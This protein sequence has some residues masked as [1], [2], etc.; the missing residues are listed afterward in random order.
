MAFV[1]V[2]GCTTLSEPTRVQR[3]SLVV[4]GGAR[5]VGLG[6]QATTSIELQAQPPRAC[7]R[8][9]RA[10]REMTGRA[11]TVALALAG[12][13]P[14]AAE[15]RWLRIGC[16]LAMS[17]FT[18]SA[19]GY[20]TA[21][22][23]PAFTGTAKVRWDGREVGYRLHSSIPAALRLEDVSAAAEA[24]A[25]RWAEAS[26]NHIRFKLERTTDEAAAPDDGVNT[27]QFVETGWEERGFDPA[28]AAITDV[29]YV[30]NSVGNWVIAEADL[31]LNAENH[32]FG[33]SS[34]VESNSRDLNSVL[35]HEVGHMLGLW[36]PCELGG[37]NGAPDCS[38][39]PDFETVTMYPVYAQH[40]VSLADDDIAGVNFLYGVTS[41]EDEG[42]PPGFMCRSDGC[43]QECGDALCGVNEFCTADGCWP[44]D[45]CYGQSCESS[46]QADAECGE[47]QVCVANTCTGRSA[48]GEPCE[49]S[50]ECATGICTEEGMCLSSC[51]DCEEG[52]CE[53]LE[54]GTRTCRSAKRA[55][56]AE[57]KA[58]EQCV[59]G[60]CLAG[61][62][63]TN[64]CTRRCTPDADPCPSGWRCSSVDETQVCTP[65]VAVHAR[66]GAGCAMSALPR[67]LAFGPW[68]LV[69]LAVL[70]ARRRARGALH[71]QRQEVI[72]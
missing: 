17:L 28:A 33:L 63:A 43:R 49:E 46:C 54:S 65:I 56:G 67:P 69:S 27:I 20:R 62:Q 16:G 10:L 3:V 72:E 18:C 24:A 52:A 21:A 71:H 11:W 5:R 40:Q 51:A 4:P 1:G 2:L 41:C 44:I 47:H 34:D 29:S 55:M 12:R 7:T 19:F 50:L 48:P 64:V 23:D 15:P 26:N 45:V 42:C 68:M 61:A 25:G 66:G 57:C 32:A 70:A 36:H 9:A 8:L 38:T 14:V 30:Q 22:D 59:G 37:S 31:Y 58:A 53:T 35:T 13:K 60:E 6:P 39:D